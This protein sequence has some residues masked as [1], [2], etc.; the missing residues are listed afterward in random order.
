M[1]LKKE[2]QSRGN[3]EFISHIPQEEVFKHMLRAKVNVLTSWIET[4]GL[5]SLEAGYARCNIVVSD[6]GT[7]RDY[8]SDF[9]CYCEPGDVVDIKNKVIEAMAKPFDER[10]R[11][12]IREKYTWEMA[13]K[14]TLEAYVSVLSI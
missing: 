14:K 10:F 4:P 2:A 7:V 1:E 6:K 13:A 5:V 8:F 12:H 9:A 11:E 3:V